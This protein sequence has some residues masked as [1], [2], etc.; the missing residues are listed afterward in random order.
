[1][2]I[3]R[4]PEHLVFGLDIGTRSIVGTV[5]YKEEK[6]GFK[7]VAQYVKEHDTRAMLDGQ[8][9]DIPKVAESIE[10]IKNELENQV[11]KKLTD[12]CIAA[13]GRVLKTITVK[14][15]YEFSSETVITD[16][17]IHSLD[18]IGVE[19]AYDE[20]REAT[21]EEDTN[22]YCVGYSVI[23]YYLN[24]YGITN[25]EGHK[26]NKIGT[27]LLA[28]FLPD[29]VIDS[30]YSAVE[31][32]GLQ[33]ANLTLE[34]I[35]AINV[36]IPEKF[37]LLNIALVDVGAGTSD[38]SITKDGSIIA[39]GM[40]PFAGDEITEAIVQRYLVEFQVGEKIKQACLKKK[41]VSFKDIMGISHKVATQEVVECVEGTV[42]NITKNIADKIIELNG[43]K[44][45]SAVFVVGG[46]GKMAGFVTT[47]AEYL[48][49][50]KERV[51]LRGEEV[52]KEVE[53]LQPSIKKDSLLVTPIGI[54]LNFYDQKNN[55]IFVQV[56]GERV[57]LYDNSKLTIVDAAIQVGFPNEL[58]F[59][60]RGK[61]INFTLNGEKRMVRGEQGEAAVVKL[62]GQVVGISSSIVQNDKIEI[63]E[64][65]IGADA[66]Y[67]VRQIPEYNKTI[68]F[69]FNGQT[70]VCPKFVMANDELVSEFYNI[71]DHDDIQILDYYTLEQVLS[72]MDLDYK[73]SI[74]VNNA[75]AQLSDKIYANFS[76]NCHLD[77]TGFEQI[78]VEAELK[79]Y[80]LDI[81]ETNSVSKDSLKKEEPNDKKTTLKQEINEIVIIVNGEAVVMN[82]KESYI[83]VDVLDFYPFDLTVAKGSSLVTAINGV[84]SGF[85][86]P[87]KDGDTIQIYWVD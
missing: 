27:K 71:K 69:I 19:K 59:P 13:A 60:R 17:H 22:F 24:D 67:E 83:L 70:I 42:R 54:C 78:D 45:V 40:I 14:A 72:F 9:H 23:T 15:D 5:G 7:V 48:N 41:T 73:G 32:A 65:T 43:G 1:M 76:I 62:N 25:L 35:A 61:P 31:R 75:P 52:L 49:L 29:E 33:V 63:V 30:L 44:P 10:Y 86:E 68:E 16:E 11:G 82:T 4:Y 81:D 18:L 74:Q 36:A 79:E 38:I 50:P 20:I 46:G 12:V 87:V 64:S 84:P 3:I 34:P 21:K 28:T 56:N 77:D 57:K 58:L 39:Y 2:E 47:L 8:I 85:T 80:E 51:A 55:F 37:R 6:N 53:F 26:A 66:T